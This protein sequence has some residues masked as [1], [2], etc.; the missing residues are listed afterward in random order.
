MN[1]HDYLPLQ[2]DVD[3]A[4]FA[5]LR[6]IFVTS[7]NG[8]FTANTTTTNGTSLHSN[9][10]VDTLKASLPWLLAIIFVVIVSGIVRAIKYRR[11]YKFEVSC[12]ELSV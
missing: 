6:N 11:S 3:A 12:M 5:N 4:I 7:W 9:T 8:N 10:V 2:S 1:V